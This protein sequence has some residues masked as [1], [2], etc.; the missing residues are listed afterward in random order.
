MYLERPS[1]PLFF[2]KD[3][4]TSLGLEE[5]EYTIEVQ[6]LI[7]EGLLEPRAQ[8][9]GQPCGLGVKITHE[10]RKL[11]ESRLGEQEQAEKKPAS[12]MWDV[13]ICHASEDKEAVARPLAQA[14][15]QK[16]LKVW[17]DEF[18][19]TLGDSLLRSLDRGLVQSRYGVV[20]LSPHFFARDWPQREL[21]GLVA[22]ELNSEKKILPVWHNVTREYVARFS[23]TLADRV[24]AST[25]E[26]MD[27]VVHKILRVVRPDVEPVAKPALFPM[28]VILERS[29][30]TTRGVF[31]LAFS[32]DGRMLAAGTQH[33]KILRWSISKGQPMESIDASQETVRSIAFSP[34]GQIL[35]SGSADNRLRLWSAI[36]GHLLDL[37]EVHSDMV[38]AVDFSPDGAKLVTGSKDNSLCLWE[39]R[40]GSASLLRMLQGHTGS[41]YAVVFSS[42]GALIASGSSDKTVRLWSIDTQEESFVLGRITGTILCVAFSPDDT[43]LAT[44]SWGGSIRLWD[45]AQRKSQRILEG[46]ND[47]VYSLAFS[48]QT[49]IFASGSKD[50]SVRLWTHPEGE[51]AFSTLRAHTGWVRSVDFSPDGLLLATGGTD[52]TIYLWRIQSAGQQP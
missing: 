51:Q 24:A 14:L 48:S 6:Y 37:Q 9:H 12:A 3:I 52:G 17:Y 16:G 40:K 44:G 34:D 45:V 31:S 19:L 36:E 10:G 43:I 26:G 41:V 30:Q 18:T 8:V 13:F 2:H 7:D 33:G 20:I 29:F 1:A 27:T 39:V 5:K 23:P 49:G 38:T 47:R 42:D 21:A 35:A 32:P 4:I 25:A 22:L 50:T 15:S 28:N 11:I 46:H